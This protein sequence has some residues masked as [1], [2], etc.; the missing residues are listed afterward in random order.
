MPWAPE[1]QLRL[2][3]IRG[4]LLLEKELN[5]VKATQLEAA[6]KLVEIFFY[7]PRFGTDHSVA[8]Q[9]AHAFFL[10]EV[11]DGY[12]VKI[13][14]KKDEETQLVAYLEAEAV[15]EAED[16]KMLEEIWESEET[17]EEEDR[18]M[19]ADSGGG[20]AEEE[21]EPEI[22]FDEVLLQAEIKKMKLQARRLEAVLSFL[23]DVIER[24]DGVHVDAGEEKRE[25]QTLIRTAGRV[26]VEVDL[27]DPTIALGYG[28]ISD[29]GLGR[30]FGT[31]R[32][33]MVLEM[34]QYLD[35]VT[36]EPDDESD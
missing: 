23:S 21:G 15:K 35:A 2:L 18:K 6:I 20:E 24:S 33:L 10:R 34:Q 22:E 8:V 36:L 28:P 31:Q 27:E 17:E 9:C 30:V 26:E 32:E 4:R 3:Q 19:E 7:G 11:H 12:W 14:D 25:F 13:D 5:D 29:E 16:V 1:T